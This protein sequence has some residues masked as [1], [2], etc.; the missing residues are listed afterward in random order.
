[1]TLWTTIIVNILLSQIQN[2]TN[3]WSL[4]FKSSSMKKNFCESSSLSKK[5]RCFSFD[6]NY[7][8]L[9]HTS[10]QKR[11]NR[12]NLF[13]FKFLK[14]SQSH[15]FTIFNFFITFLRYLQSKLTSHEKLNRVRN[16]FKDCRSIL[17]NFEMITKYWENR[18]IDDREDFETFKL[19]NKIFNKILKCLLTNQRIN[20][21]TNRRHDAREE[22]KIVLRA[23]LTNKS[24]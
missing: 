4:Y 3:R 11:R 20:E 7:F 13:E 19:I 5:N 18:K 17:L 22:K 2:F 24:K 10:F 12:N 16:I 1:M 23:C 15:N 21:L 9:K 6:R 8:R 14:S